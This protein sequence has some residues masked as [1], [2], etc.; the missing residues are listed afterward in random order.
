MAT[1]GWRQALE[2]LV[3][4]LLFCLVAAVIGYGF[5]EFG[6][7]GV[8]QSRVPPWIPEGIGWFGLSV[9]FAGFAIAGWC[10]SWAA[11]S[12][13]LFFA[14]G[15]IPIAQYRI[16]VHRAAPLWSA[17]HP[18]GTALVLVAPGALAAWVG[19]GLGALAR[20]TTAESRIPSES[21]I[22]E[23]RRRL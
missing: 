3:L 11:Y 5:G 8:P 17:F 12:W 13:V 19:A 18:Y 1:P 14:A 16:E 7:L 23:R 20:T 15:M 6:S 4:H 10:G 22:A 21:I 9:I 2:R